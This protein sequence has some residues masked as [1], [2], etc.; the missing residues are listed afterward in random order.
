MERDLAGDT[1]LGPIATIQL[2]LSDRHD[3]GRTVA[4]LGFQDGRKVV[5]KPRDCAIDDAWRRLLGWLADHAPDIRLHAP[6]VVLRADYGW[7]EY[8]EAVS[9]TDAAA[10]GRFYRRYGIL[11]ALATLLRSRDLHAENVVAFGEHPVVIDL[12]TLLSPDFGDLAEPEK[13]H[14]PRRAVRVARQQLEASVN[15]TLLLPSVAPASAEHF[16]AVGAMSPARPDAITKLEW[17]DVNTDRMRR[18][19]RHAE[20]L[21]SRSLAELDG[22]IVAP[23][24]YLR[25]ILDGFACAI[26]AVIHHRE[27]LLAPGGPLEAFAGASIRI[28]LR[29]TQF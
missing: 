24:D 9:C 15:R 6:R 20:R 7:V 12:E 11:L 2:G 19:R 18:L 5:Y 26:H 8:I 21:G 10:V 4:I 27:R 3:H 14:G 25:E 23:R 29:P 16:Y 13:R 22:F 28:V 1:S 17:V